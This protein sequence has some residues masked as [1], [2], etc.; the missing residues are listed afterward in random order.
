[1]TGAFSVYLGKHDILCIAAAALNAGKITSLSPAGFLQPAEV[2]AY[3]KNVLIAY[4]VRVKFAKR[5]AARPQ[6]LTF[7]LF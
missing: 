3:Q 1:M 7:L 4:R 5:F 2:F 6:K